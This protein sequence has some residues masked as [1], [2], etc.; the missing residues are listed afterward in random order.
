MPAVAGGQMVLGGT[1]QRMSSR[2][3]KQEL[4]HTAGSA[5]RAV[6]SSQSSRDP[7]SAM[8]ED[9]AEYSESL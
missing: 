4:K 1:T 8:A 2:Y 7:R 5:A 3:G 6:A 9:T